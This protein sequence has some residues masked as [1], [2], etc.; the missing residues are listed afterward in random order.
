MIGNRRPT[1]LHRACALPGSVRRA[2]ATPE[3]SGRGTQ[4]ASH[5]RGTRHPIRCSPESGRR[6]SRS[7]VRWLAMTLLTDSRSRTCSARLPSECWHADEVAYTSNTSRG[8]RSRRQRNAFN[9]WL[10]SKRRQREPIHRDVSGEPSSTPVIDRVVDRLGRTPSS[11]V[12]DDDDRRRQAPLI[13]AAWKSLTGVE[14]AVLELRF[15]QGKPSSEVARLLGYRSAA[16][17]DTTASRARKK[18]ASRL[19]PS[20]MAP[21][22]GG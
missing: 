12:A 4:P 17:V 8:M 9:D 15:V 13:Q 22:I 21:L 19:P 5:H 16:V 18:L 3:R 6:P 2:P 7:C 20:L 10:R 14:R 11:L 1:S